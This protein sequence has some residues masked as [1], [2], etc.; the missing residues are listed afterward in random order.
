MPM[1]REVAVPQTVMHV[2]VK[3]FSLVSGLLSYKSLKV[4]FLMAEMTDQLG[5]AKKRLTKTGAKEMSF[6]ENIAAPRIFEYLF[7][8]TNLMRPGY[9]V[10]IGLY[11]VYMLTMFCTHPVY[12]GKIARL[13]ATS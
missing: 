13:P 12:A 2:R 3:P 10:A 7:F 6:S 4:F 8:L 9:L 5:G 11:V 1:S